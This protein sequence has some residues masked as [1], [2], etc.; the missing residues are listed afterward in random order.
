M[1]SEVSVEIWTWCG[2][3]IGVLHV[4]DPNIII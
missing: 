3:K 4:E 1:G 2:G